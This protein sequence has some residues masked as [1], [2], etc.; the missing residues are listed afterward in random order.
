MSKAGKAELAAAPW[1]LE[2]RIATG[3]LIWLLLLALGSALVST[4][5]R[6]EAVGGVL[7]FGNVMYL[8]GLLL[9]LTGLLSLIAM[10]V[11]AAGTSHPG[12][13][14][15]VVW[16][17]VVAA[18]LGGLG[19]IFDRATTDVFGFWLQTIGSIALIVTLV[20]LAMA[21]FYRA[22]DTRRVWTWT[23]A[24]ASLSGAFAAFM[25]MAAAWLMVY[26]DAPKGLVG[27]YATLAGMTWQ[28]WQANLSGAYAIDMVMVVI[29]LAVATTCAAFGVE[30]AGN[31]LLK[32]GLWV[33]ALG[34]IATGTIYLT[35]GFSIA[36]P[37]ILLPHGPSGLNGI[38]AGDLVTGIGVVLGSLVALVGLGREALPDAMHRWG[39]ALVAL[40]LF[41]TASC[42]GYYIELNE[43]LYGFGALAAPRG[44]AAYV[45]NWFHQDFAFLVLPAVLV[46]MLVVRWLAADEGMR[47][48]AH[49]ALLTGAVVSFIGGILYV[50][51]SQAQ[52]GVSFVVTTIGF[53]VIVV[54][55]L[56]ALWSVSGRG[57]PKP[58][59]R[60]QRV[61]HSH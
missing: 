28:A 17:A 47:R 23:A 3:M 58:A 43:S 24:L 53:A 57:E 59:R 32:I 56:L 41:V 6:S 34:T 13:R 50:F 26:G 38:N 35:A 30:R 7:Q 46:V 15:V 39:A 5:F 20:A 4:P 54:G 8:Q 49:L 40:M 25:G 29:A 21:L 14:S 48:N 27:G 45:F 61:Q 52:N 10:N 31:R 9:G 51:V 1:S 36:Q 2:K 55:T 19:G 12:L 44:A 22:A 33:L 60:A 11:F 37:P 42:F 16:G 18:A